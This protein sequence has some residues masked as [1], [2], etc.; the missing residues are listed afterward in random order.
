MITNGT[1]QLNSTNVIFAEKS[2]AVTLVANE[3]E[4]FVDLDVVAIG[5]GAA[6]TSMEGQA[7]D[8]LRLGG[9]VFP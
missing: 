5:G 3:K 6:S 8:L 9:F 7:A 2:M 4:C 1:E